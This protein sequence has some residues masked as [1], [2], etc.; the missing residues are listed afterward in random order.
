MSDEPD[1]VTIHAFT[2]YSTRASRRKL[3]MAALTGRRLETTSAETSGIY[4]V[5]TSR[6]EMTCWGGGGGGEYAPEPNLLVEPS[7]SEPYR[8][9]VPAKPDDA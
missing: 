4:P 1:V 8:Y 3:L 6:V 7:R 2:R 9:V 5:T